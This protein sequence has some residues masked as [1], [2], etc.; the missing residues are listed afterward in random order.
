MIQMFK[1]LLDFSGT[2]KKRIDFI[3]YLSYVQFRI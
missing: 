1:R 2:E 3:V